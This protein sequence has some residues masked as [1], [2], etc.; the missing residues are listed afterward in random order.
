[1]TAGRARLIE[2]RR[3]CAFGGAGRIHFQ[4][5]RHLRTLGAGA[6]IDFQLGAGRHGLM[7][8]GL[9]CTNME[10]GVARSIAEFDKAEA[11]VALEP[12]DDGIDCIAGRGRGHLGTSKTAAKSGPGMPP[13]RLIPRGALIVEAAL[14]RASE[15]LTFAHVL[16]ISCP[17]HT[18]RTRRSLRT[19]GPQ[20]GCPHP[21]IRL[22]GRPEAPVAN[23][24]AMVFSRNCR[25]SRLS[26]IDSRTTSPLATA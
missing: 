12:F 3:R 11:L 7:T 14:L 8:G 15:F 26:L 17:T 23:P 5:A 24:L 6:D 21:G 25:K 1:M 10:E 20:S 22:S 18:Q 13:R 2:T 19:A 9:E 4:D 16:P